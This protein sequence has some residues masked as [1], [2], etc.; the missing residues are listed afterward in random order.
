MA[1]AEYT[2]NSHGQNEFRIILTE[3]EMRDF[4]QAMIDMP[5]TIQVAPIWPAVA[6]VLFLLDAGAFPTPF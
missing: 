4:Y 1:R 6:N 3:D 2:Q 5:D